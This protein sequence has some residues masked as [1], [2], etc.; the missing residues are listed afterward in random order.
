MRRG[1]ELLREQNLPL[2]DG[3]V[4]APLPRP[5]PGRRLDAPSRSSTKRLPP[6]S[7]PGHRSFEAELH[8]VRGE[9]LL[10][11]DPANPATAEDALQPPSR[12]RSGRPRAASNSARP[13]RSPSS[14]NR[15]AARRRPCRPRARARRLHAN[16]GN[17]RDRGS[18]GA[19]GRAFAE[20]DEVKVVAAQQQATYCSCTSPT[21]TRSSLRAASARRKRQKPSRGPASRPPANRSASPL[22]AHFGLWAGSYTRAELPAMRAQAAAFSR[23][24]RGATRFTGGRRR[25]SSARH[26]P[27]VRGR[28]CRSAGSSRACARP[29]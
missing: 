2:F 19:A 11:R 6:A 27:L 1:V 4:K 17:A 7:G 10:K 18:A 26:H 15:P 3:L 24:R 22:A 9:M 21:A 25:A 14:T 12:S 5:S 16:A 29:L 28:I 8:R 23:R 20:T 13:W